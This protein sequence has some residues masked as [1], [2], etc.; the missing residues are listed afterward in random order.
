LTKLGVSAFLGRFFSKTHLVTLTPSAACDRF[1][2][3]AAVSA[4][5]EKN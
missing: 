1:T 2:A 3:Q 5:N 4:V